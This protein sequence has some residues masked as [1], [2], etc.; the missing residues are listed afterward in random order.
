VIAK[1]GI[2]WTILLTA[3][4]VLA[5]CS[6]KQTDIQIARRA[7]AFTLKDVTGGTIS[8]S[9]LKGK[10]V[11][12]NVWA[13]TCPPCVEEMPLFESIQQSWQSRQDVKLLMIDEG[14]STVQV[15]SFLKD[16]NFSF[17]VLMDERDEVGLKY[18]IRYTPTTLIIDKD[19][20]LR[21]S[22][23]GSFSKQADIEKLVAPFI[24]E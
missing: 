4:L 21:A 17:T 24:A 15:N 23:V 13:T 1:T 16:R 18:N 11:L 20:M 10:T 12:I 14:E 2:F 8:L 6:S 7:P 5:G 3:I 22:V 9:G 19:G